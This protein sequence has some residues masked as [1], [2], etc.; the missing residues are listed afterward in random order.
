MK[1]PAPGIRAPASGRRAGGIR[2]GSIDRR[3]A[4]HHR[5][6]TTSAPISGG[7]RRPAALQADSSKKV[8]II[9]TASNQASRTA[10]TRSVPKRRNTPAT[11]PITIAIGIA[12]INRRTQPN[13][14]RTS[15]RTPVA[16]K[17]PT[18]SANRKCPSAGPTSTV[19]GIVQ[20]NTSGDRYSRQAAIDSRPL[21]KNAPKIQEAISA[22]DRPP[23]MPTARITATGPVA[24]KM[25]PIRPLAA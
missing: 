8:A 22:S 17:A 1:T 13:R 18:T 11:M 5:T 12:S 23:P 20:K 19:P 24:A 21:R 14:P 3:G 2:R 10:I 16:T 9:G 25:K 4:D 7:S 15:I 6:P